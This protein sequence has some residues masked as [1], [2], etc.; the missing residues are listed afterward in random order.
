MYFGEILS[1]SKDILEHT[2]EFGKTFKREV[3]D[4]FDKIMGDVELKNQESFDLPKIEDDTRGLTVDEKSSLKNK[5]GWCDKKLDEKCSIDE[6]GVIHYKTDCQSLE[7]GTANNGVP[8][9]RKTVDING[10]KIEGVFPVFDSTF[11]T[12]I[13]K[14]D[15]ERSNAKQFSDCN[16]ALKEAIG[17]DKVLKTKFTGEQL[18]DIENGDTPREYTWHH[19]EEPGHMQLVKTEDHDRTIGGAAHTGGNSLWG[20]KARERQ[21]KGEMF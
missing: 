15:Y 12:Q 6:N 3:L 4:K 8:Y 7:G 2:P 18:Q 9:E 1:E 14:E 21:E 11:D 16:K 10:V 13:P 17:N 20:N 19:T 5:L